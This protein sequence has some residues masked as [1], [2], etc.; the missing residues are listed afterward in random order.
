MAELATLKMEVM[1]YNPE[2]DKAPHAET[3]DVPYSRETSLLDAL[4]YIK[5][6]WHR[7]SL[8]VGPAVWLSVAPAA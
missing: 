1:R 5:I 4:G 8:T 2:T 6:T 3:F 7:T